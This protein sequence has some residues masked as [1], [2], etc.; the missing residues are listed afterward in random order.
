MRYFKVFK[1]FIPAFVAMISCF[2]CT[3]KNAE[4]QAVELPPMT[5]E[6]EKLIHFW[7]EADFSD[8]LT[9]RNEEL[10]QQNF[11]R[12]ITGLPEVEEE[13]FRRMA[14]KDLIDRASVDK[15]TLD[16]LTF[17]A[18]RYLYDVD[19][20]FMNDPFYMDFLEGWNS[21]EKLSEADLIRPR[22]LLEKARKNL[23]GTPAA[24]FAYVTREGTEQTLKQT[25]S[26]K[27][28]FL[29]FYEPD[30]D[31]CK[32]AFKQMG[33]D[34]GMNADL[35]AGKYDVLAVYAGD[36]EQLWRDNLDMVPANWKVGISPQIADDE[37]YDIR[38]TPQMCIIGADGLIIEK[39]LFPEL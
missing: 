19:S 36:D 25:L 15:P 9:W 24:D 34:P 22:A 3:G 6:A 8:T 20:P 32:E 1:N 33:A 2:S 26:D 29:I 31:H 7:D 12:F 18:E 5:P 37:L 27:T 13:V 11:L 28:L 17:M 39:D 16:M 38:S 30:C 35:A 14:F 10:L 23:P 4:S 21:S